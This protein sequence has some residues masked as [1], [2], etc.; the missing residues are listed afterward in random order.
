MTDRIPSVTMVPE[1]T[2][3]R[4]LKLPFMLVARADEIEPIVFDA[5]APGL[6]VGCGEFSDG[7]IE[8]DARHYLCGECNAKRVFGIAELVQMGRVLLVDD[9]SRETIAT[10]REKARPHV[11]KGFDP[12][13]VRFIRFDTS[14]EVR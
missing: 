1:P 3:L 5:A 6:C 13:S 10:L 8:P 12:L 11:A 7:E 4:P 9:P 14:R 2:P